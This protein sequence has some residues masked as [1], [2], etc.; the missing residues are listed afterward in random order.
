MRSLSLGSIGMIFK[1][2]TTS[3][4]V[5]IGRGLL[6]VVVRGGVGVPGGGG[7]RLVG[8]EDRGRVAGGRVME[9]IMCR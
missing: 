1:I 9:R 6:V 3:S 2:S 5:S 8:R 7:M 4:C